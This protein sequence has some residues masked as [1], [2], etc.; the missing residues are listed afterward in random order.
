MKVSV[1]VNAEK[2]GERKVNRRRKKRATY[3]M[4]I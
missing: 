1:I 4:K 3:E 2:R